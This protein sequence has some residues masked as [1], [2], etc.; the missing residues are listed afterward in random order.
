MA[1]YHPA[2]FLSLFKKGLFLFQKGQSEPSYFL[3]CLPWK[4][5][6]SKVFRLGKV[7]NAVF[8]DNIYPS[9]PELIFWSLCPLVKRHKNFTDVFN[10][11]LFYLIPFNKGRHEPIVRHALHLY[12]PLNCLPRR[13]YPVMSLILSYGNNI[14]IYFRAQPFVEPYLLA[15]KKPPL[16]QGGKVQKAKIHWLF[17]LVNHIS[18]QKYPGQVSLNKFY[19]LGPVWICG[20]IH[21]ILEP[22]WINVFHRALLLINRYFE[23]A[24]LI[25]SKEGQ[26]QLWKVVPLKKSCHPLSLPLFCRYIRILTNQTSC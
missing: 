1:F 14:Q 13:L 24:T 16:F 26:S 9:K 15:A 12:C 25:K 2:P 17:H 11:P 20:R 22:G 23:K 8:P 7:L 10:V 18:C 5:L 4:D 6:S 21:E 19:V 3:E